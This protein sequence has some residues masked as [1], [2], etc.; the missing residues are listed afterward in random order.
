M[1]EK[2]GQTLADTGDYEVHIIGYPSEKSH[3]YPNVHLH[4]AKRFPRLGLQRILEPFRIFQKIRELDPD[5]LMVTTHELLF[6]AVTFKMMRKASIIYD[7]REHYFR[8][9]HFLSSF[10]FVLSI[11][12]AHTVRY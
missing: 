1:F 9:I 4:L 11:L 5:I 3:D 6:A 8:N 2:I 10:T 12:I 7:I